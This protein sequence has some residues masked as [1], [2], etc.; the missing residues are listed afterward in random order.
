M[1]TLLFIKCAIVLN[2][3]KTMQKLTLDSAWSQLVC[4][5]L[6]KKPLRVKCLKVRMSVTIFI[7]PLTLLQ[8]L[9][10]ILINSTTNQIPNLS[11]VWIQGNQQALFLNFSFR[12]KLFTLLLRQFSELIDALMKQ[13]VQL[14]S[15]AIATTIL[16]DADS[17]NWGNSKDFYEV[18]FWK[19]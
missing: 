1:F 9:C 2:V 10:L 7:Y 6:S 18:S 3:N 17:T 15:Q 12:K 5:S 13:S 8:F 16:F 14:H 11:S 4:M 19:L